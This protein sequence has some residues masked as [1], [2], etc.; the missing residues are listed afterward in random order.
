MDRNIAGKSERG[1]VLIIGI[2]TVL[3]LV[4]AIIFLYDLHS[5]I[6]IKV[7]AQ[8]AADAAA[9]T[10]A[11][12]QRHSLNLIGELNLVK[13]CTVLVSD[14]VPFGDDS[15]A[16]IS[17]SSE[18]ITEMQARVSFVGP[19]IGF[20]AAQQAAK[21]NGMNPVSHFTNVVSQH[22]DN[23]M[24][25]DFYGESVGI[26]Q[27]IPDYLENQDV[28]P[29][30][31][32]GYA[33]RTPSGGGPYVQMV[34]AVNIGQ[35]GIAAA[36]NVDFAS[37]PNVDPSWLLEVGLWR[38]VASEYWCHGT[39][40]SL[41]KTFDFSGKWWQA[42]IVQNS[43]SFPEECEYSPLYIE[44]SGVG[45][46]S[47][48]DSARGAL[49]TLATERSLTV[50]DKFNRGE[51]G[52]VDNINTPLPY[53]MW[54]KYESRWADDIPSSE[55]IGNGSISYLRAS[56][57]PEYIYGGALAKMRCYAEPT[58]MSSNYK[59]SKL[60][61]DWISVSAANVAP[62]TCTALAKPLGRLAAGVPPYAASMVLPVFD[63]SRLIPVSMQDPTG[64]YDPFN[65][66]QYALFLFLK[67]AATVDDIMNPP[68]DPPCPSAY[69][70]A[71]FQKLNTQDWRSKGW[72]RDYISQTIP[73]SFDPVKN[74]TGAG[75]L[76]MGRTF[77]NDINGVPASVATTNEDTCDGWPGG[78]PGNRRGPIGP[79][80]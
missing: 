52:D 45:D 40:R 34:E 18:I 31:D 3:L 9:L 57:K 43:A 7:K 66:D 15:P 8:T 51:A 35:G 64:L 16:G 2:M 65:A 53:V 78:G 19:M 26:N 24:N 69:Y 68:A 33:W 11:N 5:I 13:A 17:T 67:W 32:K 28:D 36:P 44:Y 41:I 80:H 60:S 62:V 39:L 72:N 50:S 4:I 79:I 12:W 30:N 71:C 59:A 77:V 74:P 10:A 63:K 25:D 58:A 56:L 1:Q 29:G 73:T 75:W 38:A 42:S 70:L 22:I 55:W 37:L 54:C 21:N 47:L 14:I 23:L 76:Q 48:F 27:R 46:T 20:G 6:R 49:D 61:G